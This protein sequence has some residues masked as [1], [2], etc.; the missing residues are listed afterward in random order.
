M[1]DFVEKV[2]YFIII[3]KNALEKTRNDSNILMKNL[4]CT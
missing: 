1:T 4:Y 3:V 2:K